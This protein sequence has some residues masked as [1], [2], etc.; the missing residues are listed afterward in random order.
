MP[1]RYTS[2]YNYFSTETGM[3]AYGRIYDT[4]YS[5]ILYCYN[6]TDGK[7]LWTY[8][9]GGEGNSTASGL[10]TPWGNYPTFISDIA[11][12][13]VFLCT[14]EHSP[15]SPLYKNARYRA[16]NAT[17]GTEIWKLMQ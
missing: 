9:N 8:G 17:D 2:D 1:N 11:D 4:G 15:N 6:V 3:V 16:V 14:T 13:K 5:G 10:E 7:L 12:G